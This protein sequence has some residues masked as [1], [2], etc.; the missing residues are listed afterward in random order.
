MVELRAKLAKYKFKVLRVKFL[1][2]VVRKKEILT[3]SEKTQAVWDQSLLK[4]VK[5]LQ[6][7]LD[8]INFYQKFI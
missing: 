3:D 7:F 1:E 8:F 4:T 2:Y 5:Q 6:A